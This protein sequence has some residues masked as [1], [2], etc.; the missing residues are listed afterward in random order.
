MIFAV[1][2]SILEDVDFI[3]GIL[4]APVF[5]FFRDNDPSTP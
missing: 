1:G 5:A 2:T 3:D 4:S